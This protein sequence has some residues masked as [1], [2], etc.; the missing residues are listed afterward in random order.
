MAN[1]GAKGWSPKSS[2]V[3]GAVKPWHVLFL[4]GLSWVVSSVGAHK[5]AEHI[6]IESRMTVR[7]MA[8]SAIGASIILIFTVVVPEFRRS[9]PVLFSHPVSRPSKRDVALVFSVMLAWGYGLYQALFCFPLLHFHPELF[10]KFQYSGAVPPL[11]M[12]FL[13]F[14]A[15]AVLIAPIA[16]ELVFRGYLLNLWANR[17][18]MWPAVII[19][20]LIF[21]LVHLERAAFAAP[22]GFIF[23]LVYIRYDSL[24]PGILLHAGYN[25][26]ASP[27]VLGRYF[28]V[29][30]QESIGQFLQWWPEIVVSVLSIPLLVLFWRRF[31]PVPA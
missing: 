30:H 31:K 3:H 8:M 5:I 29:K 14:W 15:G 9:L 13:A 24:W 21:G 19:S 4:F 6:A 1:S 20:S 23:A 10:H 17:W 27:W 16:E 2:L 7:N 11:E 12:E 22:L 18:G 28:Y 26:L 25:A